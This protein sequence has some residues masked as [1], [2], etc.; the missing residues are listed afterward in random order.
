MVVPFRTFAVFSLAFGMLAAG[1][2]IGPA[3]GATH[4][5][6]SPARKA[7]AVAPAPKAPVPTVVAARPPVPLVRPQ[8]TS[9]FTP[10][11]AADSTQADAQTQTAALTT[12]QPSAE[13]DAG[14]KRAIEF[15]GYKNVH[16]V[17][18][19]SDGLWHARAMRGRTEIAVTVDASG[20][21]SAQ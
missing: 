18:K 6:P 4:S 9:Y 8:P 21:V 17:V 10:D 3:P 19:G 1:Y 5:P 16:G 20:T 13:D 2:L 11:P 12:D 15:D 14:A 7:E